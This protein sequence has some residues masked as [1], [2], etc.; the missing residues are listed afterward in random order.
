MLLVLFLKLSVELSYEVLV[1]LLQ[2]ILEYKSSTTCAET[3]PFPIPN[4]NPNPSQ[5]SSASVPYHGIKSNS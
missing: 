1:Q 4:P 5:F 2:L 3:I